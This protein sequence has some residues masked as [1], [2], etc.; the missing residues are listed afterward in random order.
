MQVNLP[1]SDLTMQIV[2][3]AT[4]RRDILTRSRR[5]NDVCDWPILLQN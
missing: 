3:A 4:Q 5:T 2:G 1:W